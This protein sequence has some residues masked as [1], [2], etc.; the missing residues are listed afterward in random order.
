MEISIRLAKTEDLETIIEIQTQAISNLPDRFRTYDLQQI[1][2]LVAGQAAMRR[3]YFS[4]ETT[5]VAEDRDR[6]LIGFI[7]LSQPLIFFQPWITGLFVH[8]NFMNR[9]VG[10]KLIEELELMAIEQGIKTLLVMA[11]MESVDFYKKNG[12]QFK[13]E[14][15]FFSQKVAWIPCELLEKAVIPPRPAQKMT[16]KAVKILLSLVFLA[17]IGTINQ[18]VKKNPSCCTVT[19]CHV[20]PQTISPN[21]K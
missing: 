16:A 14:I 21:L 8:P 20:C 13:R 18:K 10:G 7:S 12:Y 6:I 3:I 2:S 17:V 15:G 9:G 5:L 4:S 1:E 11:S 19:I